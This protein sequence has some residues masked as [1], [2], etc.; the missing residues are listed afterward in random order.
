MSATALQKIELASRSRKFLAYPAAHPSRVWGVPTIPEHWQEK[1]L[2]SVAAINTDKLPETTDPDY[3]IEYVDIGNV[4]LEAGIRTTERFRFENAPSRA[5]RKVRHGDTIV[6]TVRTYLKAVAQVVAPPDNLIVSTGFAVLRANPSFDTGF[7]YRLAQSEPLVERIMAHS[8]GV[9]YPAINASDIGKFAIP[10]PPVDEQ[11]A[12]AKFLDYETS[13]IDGLIAKKER[14]IELLREERQAIISRA[15]TKGLDPKAPMKPSGIDWLGNVP[16]HWTIRAF[17][18]SAR[19]TNG[20]VD[21]EKAQYRDL[22]LIA[23]NH[24]ESGTGR[25]LNYD[26][27]AEQAA[28]SGKYLFRAGERAL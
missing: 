8:V 10:I 23:P 7:L 3:D 25:L 26:S 1:P 27:A 24:I 18:Y 5:R 13:R 14:L 22:P 2:K 16:A 11:K 4:S 28:E 17:R 21:P 19:I 6:S 20:Q 12:I 9:S 15:V